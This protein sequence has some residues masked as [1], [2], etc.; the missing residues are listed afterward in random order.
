MASPLH[1]LDLG[2]HLRVK[3]LWNALTIALA[4]TGARRLVNKAENLVFK[5]PS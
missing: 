2:S 3:A 4:A 5:T 1:Y